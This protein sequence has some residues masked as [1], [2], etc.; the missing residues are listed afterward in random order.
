MIKL[1]SNNI[2][3]MN[4]YWEKIPP[5]KIPSTYLTL[6]GYSVAAL[7][8]SF[9]IPELNILLDCGIENGYLPDHVFI[10]HSHADHSYYLPMVF[11]ELGNFKSKV[12]KKINIY[13]PK[14]IINNAKNFISSAY[15]F[16]K[17]NPHHKNIHSKYS[18]KPVTFGNT[19]RIEIKKVLWD[20][21]II[22]CDHTVPCAGYGFNQLR[23][24]LKEEYVGMTG[25]QLDELRK[26]GIEISKEIIV[27]MFCYLGDSTINVFNNFNPEKYP[28]I[29]TECTYLYDDDIDLVKSNKHT[30]WND[31]KVIIDKYKKSTFILYHFSQRYKPSDIHTFFDDLEKKA[32]KPANIII[33]T[34]QTE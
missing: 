11:V 22:R 1:S 29:I 13:L 15:I 16:S 2:I 7:R 14:N 21:E 24:K 9:Y 4:P 30:H 5:M 33:W 18:L 26:Q 19:M 8:T 32:M 17:N 3:R 25:K 31:L 10:T 12:Q 28:T 20:I 23:K 6:L 27:P 34:E